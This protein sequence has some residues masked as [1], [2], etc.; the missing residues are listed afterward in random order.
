LLKSLQISYGTKGKIRQLFQWKGE[1]KPG[2]TAIVKLPGTI[3]AAT[4]ENEFQFELSRPNGKQDGYLPDNIMS[5]V[6]NA[7]P[8][9]GGSLVFQF[10]TNRQP[11]HNSYTLTNSTN[12]IVQQRKE[13]ELKADSLYQEQWQLQPGIYTL[14][15]KDTAGDGLEFW[16]NRRGGRGYAR[17]LDHQRRMLQPFESDFGTSLFYAF[18][19]VQDST[20]HQAP[21]ETPAV[22]LYPTMSAGPTT[23]DYFSNSAEKVTVRFISDPGNQLV[24]EHVY[25]NL[26]EG[27]FQYDMSYLPAQRY[28]VQVWVKGKMVFNKRLR[29]VFRQ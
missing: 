29:I 19:V 2:E 20:Q 27:V 5:S 21:V 4:G 13:G 22:G 28:Y 1:L 15:V 3:A 6:F 12:E 14:Q 8:K 10:K 17:L 16:F 25:E 23:L 24:E 7:I 18:E 11:I 26:K 9:H